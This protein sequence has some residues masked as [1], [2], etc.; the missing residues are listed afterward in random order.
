MIRI[1]FR[2]LHCSLQVLQS[3]LSHLFRRRKYSSELPRRR[4]VAT[5]ADGGRAAPAA[6][7]LTTGRASG[8]CGGDGV[9]SVRT[10]AEKE[11]LVGREGERIFQRP[12]PVGG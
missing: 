10:R 11:M 5:G 4:P 1:Q 2:K 6:S 8:C 9:G 3:E 12:L 7:R